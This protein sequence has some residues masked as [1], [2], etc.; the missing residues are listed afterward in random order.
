MTLHNITEAKKAALDTLHARII[1]AQQEVSY[2]QAIVTAL[3]DK[4]ATSQVLLSAADAA[5]QAAKGNKELAVQ[6]AQNADNLL[7]NAAANLNQAKLVDAGAQKMG[8][9]INSI[10]YKLAYASNVL[11]KL[12]SMVIRKKALNP[13]ISDELVQMVN[14]ACT[15]TN[16]A[17][18]LLLA[19]MQSTLSAQATAIDTHMAFELSYTLATNLYAITATGN[20]TAHSTT[21]LQQIFEDAYKNA[22]ANYT[23]AET[24]KNKAYEELN[25]AQANLAQSQA[26]LK[27]LEAGLAAANAAALAS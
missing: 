8:A 14:T 16:N 25:T 22:K 17:N 18:A 24:A 26:T 12:A 10:V 21:P 6:L 13:L 11:N 23:L 15:D 9:D 5:R 19:A 7:Q 3:A 27:S 2:M 4:A 20:K 1:T